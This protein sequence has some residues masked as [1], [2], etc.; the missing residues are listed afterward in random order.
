MMASYSLAEI[1]DGT[2][3]PSDIRFVSVADVG[4]ALDHC[5]WELAREGAITEKRCRAIYQSVI[6]A[7]SAAEAS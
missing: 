1:R 7:A 2:G 6:P 5:L 4:N 3:F